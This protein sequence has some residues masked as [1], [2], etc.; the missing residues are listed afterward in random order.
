M[1]LEEQ[2]DILLQEKIETGEIFFH[3]PLPGENKLTAEKKIIL[4]HK[5]QKLISAI[6]AFKMC[7]I[8]PSQKYIYDF[9][10]DYFSESFFKNTC[11]S[12]KN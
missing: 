1:T 5:L 9:E 11:S 3:N 7:G 2:L 6:N 10:H 4:F 8:K 12:G